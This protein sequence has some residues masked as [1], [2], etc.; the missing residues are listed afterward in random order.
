[1]L[2][3]GTLIPKAIRAQHSLHL[4]GSRDRLFRMARRA[5]YPSEIRFSLLVLGRFLTQDGIIALSTDL[6]SAVK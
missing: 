1:M 3:L 2:S 6:A 4:Q 5:S